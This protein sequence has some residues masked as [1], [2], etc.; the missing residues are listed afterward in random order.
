MPRSLTPSPPS[1]R[2]SPTAPLPPPP[3][4]PP[5]SLTPLARLAVCHNSLSPPAAP[6]VPMCLSDAPSCP[7][8]SPSLFPGSA[9]PSRGP[10]HSFALA[11]VSQSVSQL[12]NVT[13]L[14]LL[15]LFAACRPCSMLPAAPW[16]PAMLPLAIPTSI[17]GAD[18]GVTGMSAAASAM[19]LRRAWSQL[20]SLMHQVMPHTG[21]HQCQ[22]AS[23]LTALC[24]DDRA[25]ASHR[26]LLPSR[27]SL[28]QEAPSNHDGPPALADFFSRQ[29][30]ASPVARSGACD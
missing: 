24:A 2:H 21:R 23:A 30:R 4:P 22:R 7:P 14:L 9:H 17:L 15:K 3:L 26:G 28:L 12:C 1:F 8:S 19:P 11:G 5:L 27:P 6:Q 25:V 18:G 29:L 16:H 20:A 10:A 13:W